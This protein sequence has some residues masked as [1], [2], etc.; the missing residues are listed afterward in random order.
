MTGSADAGRRL[1]VDLEVETGPDAS[2]PLVTAVDAAADARITTAGDKCHVDV[3]PADGSG[4]VRASGEITDDCLC[5]VFASLGCVPRVRGVADGT[6]LVTT[7]V[8]DRTVV[9][10]VVAELEAAYD[11]VR[12][13]RLAVVEGPEADEQ[14]TV[15]LSALTTKQRR[16]LELA[17]ARG[18][19]DDDADLGDL[20]A[21][22]DVSKSALSRRL[23]TAQA[24]LIEDAFAAAGPR[25]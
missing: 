4:L 15:D 5:H 11:R 18:Y 12:L 21:E 8:D 16:G 1:R 19:F 25:R 20:A 14:V 3:R 7:Y 17:V 2:C 10:A 13:V 6:L 23:R 22:L 9:R 24:K